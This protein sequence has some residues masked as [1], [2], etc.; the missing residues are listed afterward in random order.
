[1]KLTNLG[2]VLTHIRISC[3]KT[4]INRIWIWILRLELDLFHLLPLDGYFV[5]R[6]H[7]AAELI[8]V[9]MQAVE[10]CSFGSL[11]SL[12]VPTRNTSLFPQNNTFH[13]VVHLVQFVRI[14][15]LV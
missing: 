11:G 1:M 9:E 2:N 14:M 5:T 12:I 10:P 3:Q 13:E 7:E 6:N 4:C 8:E 15:L